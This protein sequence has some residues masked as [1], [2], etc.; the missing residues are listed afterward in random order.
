MGKEGQSGTDGNKRVTPCLALCAQG[1][2]CT[3]APAPSP[4]GP[5]CHL[6]LSLQVLIP[7]PGG[8]STC[9]PV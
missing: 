9:L 1:A 5:L 2:A 3:V 8:G 6:T 7:S 4:A